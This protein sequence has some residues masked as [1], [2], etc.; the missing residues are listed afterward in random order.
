MKQPLTQ[1]RF[2][3]RRQL[4]FAR[5][6]SARDARRQ[7]TLTQLDF[8]STPT[9]E[10]EGSDVPDSDEEDD[11]SSLQPMKRR[12]LN[13]TG[14]R[15]RKDTTLTQIGF[16]GSGHVLE[17]DSDPEII[18]DSQSSSDAARSS[19]HCKQSKYLESTSIPASPGRT[20]V[21][22][23]PTAAE[24]VI[25]AVSS[26]QR[27][28]VTPRNARRTELPSSQTPASVA[29]STTH[30]GREAR[31]ESSP[32]QERSTN[33]PASPIRGSRLLKRTSTVQDSQFEDL[34]LPV[35]PHEEDSSDDDDDLNDKVYAG[36]LA[37][38]EQFTYD[39]ADSAL[40]RDAARFA[41]T[42]MHHG[43]G[44]QRKLYVQDTI[45]EEE[46]DLVEEQCH[47]LLA[48]AS[49]ATQTGL[50]PSQISTAM[51]T[52]SSPPAL[53]YTSASTQR[54]TD[55]VVIS[56]SPSLPQPSWH[57]AG[58]LTNDTALQTLS[59]FSLPPPPP[60]NWESSQISLRRSS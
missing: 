46:V 30:R 19:Q 41:V 45:D 50:P 56:S 49:T 13:S 35:Q 39:P 26:A 8:V 52:Q 6:H 60:L 9:N 47:A 42:Q 2:P 29:L 44:S 16:V 15:I 25:D 1:K 31:T 53:L 22:C 33:I 34:E 21:I 5:A 18:G 57:P 37:G 24:P 12:K 40:D 3:H 43:G 38:E 4:T 59:D 11:L 20:N 14:S 48:V 17:P 51:S 27:P 58:K 32:L 55:T 54:Q 7:S 10:H 23:E 28:T 36:T